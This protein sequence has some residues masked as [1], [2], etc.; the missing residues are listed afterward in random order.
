MFI[1]IAD[2]FIFGTFGKININIQY[3]IL[4]RLY[5]YFFKLLRTIP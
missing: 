1:L 2:S 3:F 4:S 5:F